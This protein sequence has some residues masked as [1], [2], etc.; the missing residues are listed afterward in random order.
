M[1]KILTVILVLLIFRFIIKYVAPIFQ[2]T[3]MAQ[4][5]MKQM[6]DQMEQMQQKEQP[7]KNTS[8]AKAVDGEYI[9]YE[10]VK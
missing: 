7:K 3:R 9:D 5:R 2:M 10:E 8:Q 4:S 6:Q 1:G